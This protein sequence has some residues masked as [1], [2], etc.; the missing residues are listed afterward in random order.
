MPTPQPEQQPNRP[1]QQERFAEQ[2]AES[3]AE[4]LEALSSPELAKRIGELAQEAMQSRESRVMAY[5]QAVANLGERLSESTR[6][7]IGQLLE[8]ARPQLERLQMILEVLQQET[9]LQM[10]SQGSRMENSSEPSPE[11][12]VAAAAPVETFTESVEEAS[13][14]ET[15]P[16]LVAQQTAN[17]TA[18]H[19]TSPGATDLDVNLPQPPVLDE[20]TSTTDDAT[21]HHQAGPDITLAA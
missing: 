2:R 21:D 1:E 14:T 10:E 16:T 15:D 9:G 17:S 18:V 13:E 4:Q 20:D 19:S 6:L 3:Q 7:E 12:E 11:A 5:E 8:S